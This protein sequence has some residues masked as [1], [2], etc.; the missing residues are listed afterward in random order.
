MTQL[1]H[2]NQAGDVHMVDV[3]DKQITQRTAVAEGYIEMLPAT[4]ELILSGE[5]RKGDV[6]GTARLAGIMASKKTAELIPLC[7]PLPLAHVN[8][9]LTPEREGNRV[10]CRTTVKTDGK[11]GGNT[12]CQRHQD[13]GQ[14]GRHR[15]PEITEI[16]FP[17]TPE[18]EYS[19]D[20]QSRRRSKDWYRT[21]QRRKEKGEDKKAGCHQ[22]GKSSPGP[23]GYS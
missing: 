15:N 18:H 11:T 8:I 12:E 3:G 9:E 17:D 23:I 7:H 16:Y 2:F 4:L 20:N 21:D 10:Y 14:K 6:L 5:N 1:T 22:R 19:Y 13:D